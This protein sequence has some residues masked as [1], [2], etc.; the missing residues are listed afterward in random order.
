M[1]QPDKLKGLK[2]GDDVILRTHLE[3]PRAAKVSEVTHSHAFI[4][5]GVLR[6]G[7]AEIP[8]TRRFRLH[9]GW[10]EGNSYTRP[11]V[12]ELA[13]KESTDELLGF[14]EAAALRVLISNAKLKRVPLVALRQIT[15]ILKFHGAVS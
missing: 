15:E 10:E 12:M 13:T 6:D 8:L 2:A 3:A 1:K 7:S 4:V 11:A 9:D 14:T 5:S